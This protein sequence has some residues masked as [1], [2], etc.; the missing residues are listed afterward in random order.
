MDP[1]AGAHAAGGGRAGIGHTLDQ[2]L[3][4]RSQGV[5]ARHGRHRGGRL[6]RP[7]RVASRH[8]RRGTLAHGGQ[9]GHG[10]HVEAVPA[11]IDPD[12][13]DHRGIVQP[14]RQCGGQTVPL[15][16]GVGERQV[17]I[18]GRAD[19]GQGLLHRRPAPGQAA[20]DGGEMAPNEIDDGGALD[21][22]D[23]GVGCGDLTSRVGFEDLRQHRSSPKGTMPLFACRRHG[24]RTMAQTG[25]SSTLRW[26]PG[27]RGHLRDHPPRSMPRSGR[28][29]EQPT[30]CCRL[31]SR[32]PILEP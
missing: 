29:S 32:Q 1:E 27:D 30:G 20:F 11:V 31:G 5:E 3:L 19:G 23:A 22:L 26:E 16:Q 9:G 2:S 10:Q 4:G 24:P 13:V 15:H 17:A 14:Q 25:W 28:H 6:V 12:H 7:G 18:R 21:L 8:R